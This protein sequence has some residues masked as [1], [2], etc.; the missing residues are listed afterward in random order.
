MIDVG[1]PSMLRAAAKNFA[2]VTVVSSPSQYDGCPVASCATTATRGPRHGKRLAREAFETT[3]A[4]EAAI[5]NWFGE[6]R[7]VPG[8]ADDRPPQGHRPL[9]RRE[10]P[11]GGGVL[12]RAR[13]RAGTCSR[14][15]EQLGGKELSY[16]NLGDLEGARRIARELTLPAAV[17]VKHAN[18]CGVAV[19]AT[20][21]EAWE[22][23]LAA[24][25]V[26]AFG[27]VAVLNRPVGA[28]LGARIGGHFA[29]VLLAPGYDAGGGRRAAREE[30]A[31]DPGRPRAPPGHAGRAR[32]QARARRAARAGARRRRRG[33]RR[34]CSSS[35]ASST[36]QQWADLLFAWRVCKH[37]SSN[38]IVL[39]RDLQTI[40][41]GAGQMSRVDAVR[42]AV[43]KAREHGHETAGAVA[44]ERRVLPVRGRPA[45][46]ARRG[47]RRADPA[48][49]LD[50]RRRDGGGGRGGRRS[51]GLHRPEALPALMPAPPHSE[52]AATRSSGR[53]ARTWSP[54]L[55]VEPGSIV[56]L[57]TNDCF[58]GQI[59]TEADLVTEIDF[60]RVN[61]ATGPIAVSGAEPGDSLVVELLEMRPAERGFATLIPG[62]GQLI[63]QVHAPLTQVFRVEGDTVHMNERISFPLAPDGGRDRRRDRRRDDRQRLSRAVTAATSTTTCTAPARRSTCRCASRAGCSRSAT[64]TRRWAT[65]RCAS[66]ASRSR[67][68]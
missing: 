37:V 19:A 26:S 49:R 42:I 10:P 51:D 58:T 4:Y 15:I 50:P 6:H 61:S 11:P 5:A 66:P 56:T 57:E 24:D 41:I 43:E 52:S 40:G 44:C 36:R 35:P 28:E 32:L 34:R 13:R 29:E 25:P 47:H 55:E 12:P 64:C 21:E 2:H 59:Q 30:G 38:A 31:A 18:P 9:V 20:I 53:S 48:G 22:R 27:C 67:A 7:A 39:V 8:P 14:G 60:Q 1:G 3:A 23:A 68:R 65:A 45:A 54:V 62:I 63:D 33:A 46:R 17:I 16:N